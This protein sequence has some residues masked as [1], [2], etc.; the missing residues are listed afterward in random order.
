[1]DE[2]EMR[3]LMLAHGTAEME[4][5]WSAAFA[6]MTDDFVYRF[7]PYRLQISGADAIVELWS[8][9]FTPS[10][11]LRCFDQSAR[12]PETARMDEYV[13]DHS[14]VR[15]S[16]S[17]FVDEDGGRQTSSHVTRFDFAGDLACAET[18]FVDSSLMAYLDGV[19]DDTFR[20][21]PGVE[22]F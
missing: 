21:L 10:G 17:A 13:N 8:R 7:Y 22:P 1:M 12:L 19:F 16:S 2:T 11:P 9:M 5:D 14:F 6:T 3:A 18:L 15:I 20:S 4:R